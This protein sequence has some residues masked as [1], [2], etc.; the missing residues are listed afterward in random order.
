ML[1]TCYLK[2]S[3]MLKEYLDYLSI[4]LFSLREGISSYQSKE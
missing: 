3:L 1:C 4:F 2:D